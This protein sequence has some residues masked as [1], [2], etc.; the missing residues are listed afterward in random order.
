[1][2][3]LKPNDAEHGQKLKENKGNKKKIIDKNLKKSN[4]KLSELMNIGNLHHLMIKAS[5]Y[6]Y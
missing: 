6:Y 2:D 3:S 1:M 4:R 5:S